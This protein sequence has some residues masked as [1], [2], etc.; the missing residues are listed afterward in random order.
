M[1]NS[2]SGES[3]ISRAMRVIEAFTAGSTVLGV[4]EVAQRTGL[5]L[6][7]AHRIVAELEAERVLERDSQR[8]IRMGTRL[9]EISQ[10]SSR[11]MSL[12]MAALP[13]MH[14]LQAL[15]K[16]H[17]Q[18]AVISDGEVLYLERL[19]RRNAVVNLAHPA[20]RIPP[21]LCSSGLAL[22]AEAPREVQSRVTDGPLTV[23]TDHS[24]RTGDQL[25][26]ILAEARRRGFAVS[27]GYIQPT[28][29]GIAVPVRDP[30]GRT[31]AALSVVVPLEVDHLPIIPA[32]ITA[33]RLITEGL[34]PHH[35]TSDDDPWRVRGT[36]QRASRP[37]TTGADAD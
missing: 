8:K 11:E 29:K 33:S 20:S 12:R 9:W 6:A 22:L 21:Y 1:A 30:D 24:I 16:S 31:V 10:R 15:V 25:R 13:V 14:D 3:V 26:A 34:A 2:A 4:S 7:T 37:R 35:Y 27:Y 23:S 5:P 28:A 32:M 18:L 19:S 36:G 17:V